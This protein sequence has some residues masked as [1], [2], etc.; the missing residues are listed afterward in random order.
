MPLRSELPADHSK[1]SGYDTLNDSGEASCFMDN[2]GWLDDDP[3]DYRRAKH[4][5]ANDALLLGSMLDQTVNGSSGFPRDI[6]PSLS[7]NF[8]NQFCLDGIFPTTVNYPLLVVSPLNLPAVLEPFPEVEIDG[9]QSSSSSSSPSLMY[10]A[11]YTTDFND[12]AASLSL[13]SNA[14]Q[15]SLLYNII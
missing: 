4:P 3:L 1:G 13:A 9:S 12:D 10:S 11:L 14:S 15:D 6:Y 5:P 8:K 2:N 7:S